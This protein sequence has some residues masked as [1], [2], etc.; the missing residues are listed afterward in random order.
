[1]KADAY[2][3]VTNGEE[4]RLVDQNGDFLEE[5]RFSLWCGYT[6]S[7]C[8]FKTKEEA[9]QKARSLSWMKC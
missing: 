2:T 5:S 1:M 8:R 4:F 6:Y 9:E 3:V 7:V